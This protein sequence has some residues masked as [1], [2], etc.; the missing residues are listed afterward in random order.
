MAAPSLPAPSAV[1]TTLIDAIAAIPLDASPP[2]PP[3]RPG[4]DPTSHG[5]DNSSSSSSTNAL[6][7]VPFAYRYL[8]VTLHV[9]FPSQLLPALD[10]LDRGLVTRL[11]MDSTPPAGKPEEAQQQAPPS[12]YYVRSAQS[13]STRGRKRSGSA[14]ANCTGFTAGA[15]AG[16]AY[17]VRL[18]AWNCTCAAFAFAAFAHAGQ[19][20]EEPAVTTGAMDLDDGVARG[21]GEEGIWSFG[22]MNFTGADGDAVDEATPACKHLLACLLAE[23]WS[24]ALGRYV[25]ERRVGREEMAGIVADV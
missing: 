1:L 15:G 16:R 8:V 12:F 19:A 22:G 2:A 4:R 14:I 21:G 5:E 23:R 18:T 9:L 25:V 20:V 6:R 10:L 13:G 11:I 24:A 3:P 7:R 17:T